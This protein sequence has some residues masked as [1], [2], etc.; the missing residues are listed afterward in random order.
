MKKIVYLM[1]MIVAGFSYSCKDMDSMYKEFLVPNGVVYPQKADSLKIYS[2]VGK[3]RITWF[4]AK[5]PNVAKARIY[6]NNYTDST[7]VSIPANNEIIS[8]DIAN[9][10]ENTYT[11]YVV[12]YDDDGNASIPSEITGAVFGD[13]YIISL[14]RRTILSELVD[15][16]GVWK[17]NWGSANVTE[18]AIASEIEYQKLDGSKKTVTIPASESVTIISDAEAGTEY[19]YR[20]LYFVPGKFMETVYSNYETR[21]VSTKFEEVLIPRDRFRNAALPGDY[22]TAYSST[23]VLEKLWDG[24]ISGLYSTEILNPPKAPQH[25]TIELGR[26]VIISRFNMYPRSTTNELYK[27]AGPRFF[28]IWGSMDPP[29]DGSWDNWYKLGEWQQLKPSGYGAGADVG[30]VTAADEAWFR[31]GGNYTV[32]ATDAIPNPFIPIKYLRFIIVHTFGSYAGAASG[33]L[34]IAELEFYGGIFE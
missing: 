30:T 23:Y 6:W 19:R 26:T 1:I 15:G 18:G 24:G 3:V 11:F 2:G 31:S 17:I 27:S 13:T 16:T 4:K 20:T 21:T 9:L 5:D 32:E 10:N 7:N 29:S 25:F 22:Y 12:T 8:V 28:E 14:A 33:N 34:T